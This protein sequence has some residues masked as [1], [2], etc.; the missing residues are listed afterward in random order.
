MG[1][2]LNKNG[3]D[4]NRNITPGEQ[5]ALHECLTWCRGLGRCALCLHRTLLHPHL[6]TT[7]V[8]VQHQ[9]RQGTNNKVLR[10]FS[11]IFENFH[12]AST[13]LMDKIRSALPEGTTACRIRAA[14]R[15]SHR[16]RTG[17]LL[18]TLGEESQGMVFLDP[19]CMRTRM[20][21]RP[22]CCILAPQ[23]CRFCGRAPFIF[24][25]WP[26]PHKGGMCMG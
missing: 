3:A 7:R 6:A 12:T 25:P 9:G 1:F 23:G 11:T 17:T 22:A 8:H 13:Q 24:V 26:T 16:P 19:V 10:M 20:Q 5:A 21:G 18:E 14:A 2:V 15:E 4:L